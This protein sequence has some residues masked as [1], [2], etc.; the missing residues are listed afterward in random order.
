VTPPRSVVATVAT[1]TD[2]DSLRAAEER[3]Q[4]AQVAADVD[5][6]DGIVH[7]DVSYVGPDGSVIGKETDLSGHR[8]GALR[9]RSLRPENLAVRVRFALGSHGL[10][11]GSEA[12]PERRC[13]AGGLY[14]RALQGRA[15][16]TPW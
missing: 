15:V 10:R 2:T 14:A 12:G 11:R 13:Y 6:L 7:P 5:A 3:L 9:I 16:E 4:E 1:V 8:S